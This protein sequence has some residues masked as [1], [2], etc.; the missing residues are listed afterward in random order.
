MEFLHV[1]LQ[2]RQQGNVPWGVAGDKCICLP[3]LV[4]VFDDSMLGLLFHGIL[5]DL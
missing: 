4:D 1:R 3:Q 5:F 2:V